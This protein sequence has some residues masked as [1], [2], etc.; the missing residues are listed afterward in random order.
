MKKIAGKTP[1]RLRT[2]LLI[3]L[4]IASLTQGTAPASGSETVDKND[5][6]K[7]TNIKLQVYAET[8]IEHT[9]NVFRLTESQISKMVANEIEDAVSGRFKDMESVSDNIISP[10]V[11][12]SL[13]S[14]SPLGGKLS[15]A[16]WIRYNYYTENRKSSFPEGRIRLRNSFGK[17]VTLTLEGNFLFD[18]FKK[19]YLSDVN[20]ENENGNIPREERIYSSAIYDEYEGIIAY[21]HEMINRQDGRLTGLAFQPFA[22][23][24]LR[25]YNAIFGNRDQDIAF[26]GIE[27]DL[28]FVSRLDLEM[29]YLYEDVA[30]PGKRELILYDET[31]SGTD[32]NNDGEIKGNAPLLT[33][34]DRSSSRHAIEIYPSFKLTKDTRIF[35]GYEKRIAECA[36]GNELDIEHYNQ[37]EYRRQ[38]KSGIRHDFSKKWTAEAEYGR[39]TEEEEDGDYSENSFIVKIKY[40]F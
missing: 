12:L 16:S 23:Y 32:Y 11:G 8:G 20:D 17:K 4:V 36:S 3:S 24:R 26:L 19:N 13:D 21:E 5:A 27:L 39:T 9:D 33:V 40:D 6:D 1:F 15:M 2:L 37:K 22:G 34:I 29:I 35:L 31:V 25:K 7:K 28:E 14:D 18:F 10:E 38:I 30:T